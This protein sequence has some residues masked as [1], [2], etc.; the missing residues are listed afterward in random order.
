MNILANGAAVL[1]MVAHIG[2]MADS[3]EQIEEPAE[4]PTADAQKATSSA[5]SEK[6]APAVSEERQAKSTAKD[7][8]RTEEKERVICTK[9]AMSGTRLP[10]RRICRTEREWELIEGTGRETA[11][12]IQRMPIPIKTE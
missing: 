11:E 12:Q 2:V 4:K 1:M 10:N 7:V 8:T 6:S 3:D 5:E 9:Q